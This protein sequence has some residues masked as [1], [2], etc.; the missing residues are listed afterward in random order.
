MRYSRAL[1]AQRRSLG[2]LDSVWGVDDILTVAQWLLSDIRCK[3]SV[4]K[5]KNPNYRLASC[6]VFP[7]IS[8]FAIALNC[9]FWGT[10]FYSQNE[11]FFFEAAVTCAC[12]G[13]SAMLFV[14]DR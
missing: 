14:A 8:Y 3:R 6:T 11:D 2:N 1:A 7:H 9:I 10:C 12:S 4:V 5:I 13:E